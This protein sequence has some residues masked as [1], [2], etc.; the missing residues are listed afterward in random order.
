[1]AAFFCLQDTYTYL[2]IRTGISVILFEQKDEF[3]RL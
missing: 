2:R 3:F 1:M